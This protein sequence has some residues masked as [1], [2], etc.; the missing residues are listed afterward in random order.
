M[1]KKVTFYDPHPGMGGATL[2]LPEAMKKAIDPL[3]GKTA[4]LEEIMDKLQP[5]AKK[6]EGELIADEE[7]KYITF[8]MHRGKLVHSYKLLSYK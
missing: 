8:T 7:N 6:L 1:E 2:R 3:N 4:S 5:V